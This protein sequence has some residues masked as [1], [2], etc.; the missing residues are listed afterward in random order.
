M[1]IEFLIT[2]HKRKATLLN[3]LIIDWQYIQSL[4]P[5]IINND[6]LQSS[7]DLKDAC[8]TLKKILERTEEGI[9]ELN[10]IVPSFN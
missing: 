2:E 4:A 3:N 9:K 7:P 1:D 8:N 6:N 5:Q 10:L